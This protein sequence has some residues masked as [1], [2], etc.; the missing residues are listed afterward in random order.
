M[1]MEKFKLIRMKETLKTLVQNYIK[2]YIYI[3]TK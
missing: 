3:K 2:K 1:R